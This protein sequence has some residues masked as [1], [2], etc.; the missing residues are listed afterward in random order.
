MYMSEPQ[1][2][3][4][5]V[6]VPAS[7]VFVLTLTVLGTIGLGVFPSPILQ[8]AQQSVLPLP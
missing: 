4:A 8:F 7:L 2:N 3:L 1:G 6:P 5:V